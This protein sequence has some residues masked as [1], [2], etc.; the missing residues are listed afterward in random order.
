MEFEQENEKRKKFY[1]TPPAIP[2]AA[3]TLSK[4]KKSGKAVCVEAEKKSRVF[5]ARFRCVA[6]SLFF[7]VPHEPARLSELRNPPNT[8]AMKLLM[9]DCT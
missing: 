5:V 8:H 3:N 4:Q 1:R 2:E 9:T 6:F 7:I